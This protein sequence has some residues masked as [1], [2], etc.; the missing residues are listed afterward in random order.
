MRR[1]ETFE[2]ALGRTARKRG[3]DFSGY[4]RIISEVRELARSKGTDPESAARDML[5]ESDKDS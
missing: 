4:V 3:L 2:E 1:R 5:R